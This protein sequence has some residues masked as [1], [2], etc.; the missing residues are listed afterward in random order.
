MSLN[1]T[2]PILIIWA[3]NCLLGILIA[4]RQAWVPYMDAGKDIYVSIKSDPFDGTIMPIRYVPDWTLS[5]ATRKTKKFEDFL[6]SEFI[7]IPTYDPQTLAIED[8]RSRSRLIERYTYITAYM[9]SYRGNYRESDGSHNAVDIRV[10]LHTPVLSIANGVVV[11][12]VQADATGN[13]FIVIRHDHVPL[14]EGGEGNLY[15]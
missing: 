6:L 14:P 15:S 10:P 3:I 11:R 12:V 7:P 4:V 2:K 5:D 8:L 1:L 9:G 13:K